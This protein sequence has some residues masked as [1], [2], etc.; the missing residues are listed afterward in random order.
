MVDMAAGWAG[1]F[2]EATIAEAQTGAVAAIAPVAAEELVLQVE[3]RAAPV[4][5]PLA[6]VP[7]LAPGAAERVARAKAL[8]LVA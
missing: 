5:A 6:L 8:T 2:S 7:A 4:A 1:L 3:G